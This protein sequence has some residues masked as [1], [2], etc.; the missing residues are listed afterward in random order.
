MRHFLI[1]DSVR[2]F[3][4]CNIDQ[5]MGKFGFKAFR[6]LA[7]WK[8]YTRQISIETNKTVLLYRNI[9]WAHFS[10][11]LSMCL[12]HPLN[13]WHIFTAIRHCELSNFL[14]PFS[15]AHIKNMA[16]GLENILTTENSAQ[17][18]HFKVMKQPAYIGISAFVWCSQM[19]VLRKGMEG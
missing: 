18:H 5:E 7:E 8:L 1:F 3:A 2:T 11:Q 14:F 9:F 13:M 17:Q 10:L 6:R 19:S 15:G 16:F 4:C 12:S